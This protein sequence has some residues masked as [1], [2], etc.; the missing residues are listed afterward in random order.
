MSSYYG[1]V[2]G[3][4]D[5]LTGSPSR[6]ALLNSNAISVPFLHHHPHPHHNFHQ[7]H[8]QQHTYTPASHDLTVL[9]AAAAAGTTTHT[10]MPY[11]E[12]TVSSGHMASSPRFYAGSA[13]SS[14]SPSLTGGG[15]P[16]HQHL[17]QAIIFETAT[18]PV[19]SVREIDFKVEVSYTN[20][21]TLFTLSTRFC[22]ASCP[23]S[24]L[25]TTPEEAS[26]RQPRQQ[27]EEASALQQ[28]S[29]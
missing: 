22:S 4:G 19:D 16:D 3:G 20:P 24:R 10:A 5:A 11:L 6:A 9:T 18:M 27:V 12:Q 13:A 21:L 8:Q 29:S 25:T 2:S 14:H 23:P 7:L 17:Q 1:G 26:T 15:V 28:R